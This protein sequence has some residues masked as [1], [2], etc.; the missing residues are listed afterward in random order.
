MTVGKTV[1]TLEIPLYNSGPA[2][3]G[4]TVFGRSA[5]NPT[6]RQGDMGVFIK[7]VVPG[8]AAA[9]VSCHYI[10]IPHL[11]TSTHHPSQQHS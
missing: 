10:S 1:L 9:L 7:A 3:L 6:R 2:G 11:L 5:I 8:G 4:V